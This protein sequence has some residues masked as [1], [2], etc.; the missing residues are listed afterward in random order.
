[1]RKLESKTKEPKPPTAIYRMYD[2]KS[3][4][5]LFEAKADLFQ[6][7]YKPY[8]MARETN[9]SLPHESDFGNEELCL[10]TIEYLT[11]K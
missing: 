11:K 2:P 4:E 9:P 1:M 7:L 6:E 10:W 3:E 8:R 5:L